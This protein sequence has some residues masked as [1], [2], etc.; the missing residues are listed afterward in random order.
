M[1]VENIKKTATFKSFPC[2]SYK[3]TFKSTFKL[4]P[5]PWVEYPY[6]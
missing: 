6:F 5:V 3:N 4:G 1:E 2:I